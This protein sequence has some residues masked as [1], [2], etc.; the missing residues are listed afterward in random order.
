ME[1]V[2]SSNA[3][4]VLSGSTATVKASAASKQPTPSTPYKGTY[5]LNLPYPDQNVDSW[6]EDIDFYAGP[7]TIEL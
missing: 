1:K 4:V 6:T 5:K 3:N 2:T 7:A